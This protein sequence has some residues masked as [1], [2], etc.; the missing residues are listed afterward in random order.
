[1]QQSFMDYAHRD[2]GSR[3]FVD[4]N[5]AMQNLRFVSITD[6]SGILC[7][8]GTRQKRKINT[9]SFCV[10]LLLVLYLLFLPH[11]TRLQK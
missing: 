11:A 2:L 9:F 5:T 6:F 8:V 1:M 4:L 10:F 7:K 3:D